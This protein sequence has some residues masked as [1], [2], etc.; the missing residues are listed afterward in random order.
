MR[1]LLKKEASLELIL[2]YLYTSA[3]TSRGKGLKKKGLK[4]K[5]VLQYV[6]FVV[7]QTHLS[8]QNNNVSQPVNCRTNG[9]F[10]L[11]AEQFSCRS[12]NLSWLL[13]LKLFCQSSFKIKCR[14]LISEMFFFVATGPEKCLTK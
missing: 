9:F 7:A 12:A 6:L 2:M 1:N 5:I 8:R 10:C 11:K 4:K 3:P 13:L 14:R